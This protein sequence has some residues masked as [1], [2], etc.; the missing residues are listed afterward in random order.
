MLFVPAGG[1]A[2]LKGGETSAPSHV[3]F[4]GIKPFSSKAVLL[5][6]ISIPSSAKVLVLIKNKEY[7]RTIITAGILLI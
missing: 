3:Y 1:F 2:H 5:T 4:L 7:T 6:C